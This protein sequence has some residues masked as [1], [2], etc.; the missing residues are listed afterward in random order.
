VLL[1]GGACAALVVAGAG[2]F[3]ADAVAL[4]GRRRPAWLRVTVEQ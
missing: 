4:R 1:L 3:S 2:R